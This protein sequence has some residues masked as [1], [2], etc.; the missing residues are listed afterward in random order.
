[1]Y[2]SYFG[3]AEAPFSIA[4]DPRY[5]YL[6][7]R[8]EEALAHLLYGVNG[9]GGFVLLTGEV[10]AGKTTVCRCLLEQIPETCDVAYI[11]NPKL[12]VE[13]L[14]S[15]ICVE[16][17]IS[18]PPG[19]TSIKVFVDCLNAYLLDANARGRHTVLIIDEAQNLSADVLEQMR[20]L[21][22]LETNQHK[23]LQI[24]LLGQP[25]L[26][27]MLERP[28]LRQLAQRIVA[29]YHLGPLTKPE[30]AAYVRHRLEV[31][32][33]QRQLFPA[34]LMGRLYRLSGGI[35]RVIN[36]LCDRA[37]LGT[38]VQGKE[39]VDRATLAKAAREVRRKPTARR[40]MIRAV[41]AG[42][43]L[44][45]G[46]T[47]AVVAYQQE[48]REAKTASLPEVAAK[49]AT[50]A[51]QPEDKTETAAPAAG[52]PDALQWP[53]DQARS[54]SKAIAYA[55][56]F[57]LWN[58]DY[59]GGDGCQEAER[60]GLRCRAARGGLDEVRQLNRPAVLQ[61]RDDRGQEFHAAL[62]ALDDKSATFALGAE[63][64]V[65]SLGALAAQWS[66][67]YTVLWRLPGEAREN[68]RQGESGPAVQWLSR[69]LAQLQGRAVDTGKELLFDD[70]LVRQ[71]KQFQLAQGLVPDGAVGPQ[72]LMRLSAVADQ[73]APKLRRE[74]G[75]K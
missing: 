39:R 23:L 58:L 55:A 11:F 42:L 64:K 34:A 21:T 17:G 45:A 48:W 29:H 41:S 31:S 32:G 69:Q 47:L 74:Q 37:L 62:T 50:P 30:V 72:T 6:S 40:G 15:T 53:A 52:L 51:A 36:V 59:Q 10:G 9:E 1:M 8:H 67:R 71:V 5:L 27:L 18:Y 2:Q 66:G 35:P 56:L 57:R 28:E 19:N 4:P 14:L 20:L 70:V 54:R 60:L 16:F 3:L 73:A 61:M 7:Q 44:L 46:G 22:N 26:A 24:I 63:S 38:Y 75:G 68:I 13:E 25:E 33:A 12:T 65:I 43:I 49:P